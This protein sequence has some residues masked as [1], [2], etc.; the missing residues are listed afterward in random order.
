MGLLNNP[1]ALVND[2]LTLLNNP[3]LWFACIAIAWILLPRAGTRRR[4]A[5]VNRYR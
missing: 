3:W 4:R 5:N 2:P 1:M